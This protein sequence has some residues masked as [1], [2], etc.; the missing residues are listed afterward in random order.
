MGY[1]I[2]ATAALMFLGASMYALTAGSAW[3]INRVN[4]PGWM[5]YCFA[6]WMPAYLGSLVVA[7]M[8]F[9]SIA[10]IKP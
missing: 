8:I 5:A 6:I 3:V 10:G 9:A 2:G 4:L 1:A 7:F